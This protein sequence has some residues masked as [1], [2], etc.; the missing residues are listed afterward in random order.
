MS[1]TGGKRTLPPLLTSAMVGEWVLTFGTA[2]N[3]ETWT[4]LNLLPDVQHRST[5]S[6]HFEKLIT[7]EAVGKLSG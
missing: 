4:S 1:A 6:P 7:A 2:P 5:I 3:G